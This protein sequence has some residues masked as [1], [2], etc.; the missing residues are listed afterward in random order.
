[1]AYRY[2]IYYSPSTECALGAF[3][4]EWLGRTIAGEELAAPRLSGISSTDWQMAVAAPRKYGFHA[5]LKPPFRL[6]DGANENELVSALTEFCA[7][8]TTADLGV[9]QIDRIAGFLA[10]TPEHPD[11]VGRLAADIVRAFD[12]FRA[13]STPE[14]IA[15]RQP[16]KLTP[17]QRRLLNRWGYPY[18]L[19]EYRFHMTITGHLTDPETPKFLKTLKARY[20]QLVE[21]AVSI[22]DVCLFRQETRKD[23]L[24]LTARYP[25]SGN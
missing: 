5:T 14:E 18:V 21:Q 6:A 13:P 24:V 15:R 4:A 1:M 7:S 23:Q 2:A 9:L 3:G 17:T 19:E 20:A 25:L 22:E 8:N 11:A 10:L 12:H 16:E